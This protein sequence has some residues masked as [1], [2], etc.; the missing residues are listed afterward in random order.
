VV[1]TGVARQLFAVCF[2]A[3][4]A[5][6]EIIVPT[7]LDWFIIGVSTILPAAVLETAKK[8]LRTRENLK[9]V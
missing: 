3:L 8:G 7:T 5:I 4:A 9:T 1:G 6:L 2:P